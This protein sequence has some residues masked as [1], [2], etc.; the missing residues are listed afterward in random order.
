LQAA[1]VAALA[2]RLTELMVDAEAVSH[3]HKPTATWN[4]RDF[5]VTIGDRDWEDAER[6]GYVAAGGGETYTKPL[7]NL[8]P[9]AR[10]FLY[11]PY[12]VK[13]FVGVGIVKEK[14]R[15]VTD[16]DVEL[17]G[18]RISILDAPL[19]DPEKVTHDAADPALQ[20]HLVR[21]EWLRTRPVEDAIWQ[22]GLFTNQVPACKLR[23]GE[24]IEY[25]EQAFDVSSAEPAD[26]AEPLLRVE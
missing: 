17:D 1:E 6:Y 3:E 12:P 9:G 5:Y 7:E 16:F 20:E 4:G 25:L 15:P 19:A 26:G 14:S 8:F 24:T 10:V 18:Q 13:G 2:E 22:P 21:V 11:K 23:D